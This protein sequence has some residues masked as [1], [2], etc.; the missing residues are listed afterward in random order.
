MIGGLRLVMRPP[1]DP[2][3]TFRTMGQAGG[4]SDKREAPLSRLW[5]RAKAGAPR[6][7]AI[8]STV[9]TVRRS[10]PV[11]TAQARAALIAEAARQGVDDLSDK[12]LSTMTDAV[13][14]SA[15]EGASQA[16][17]K[18]T[19]GVKSLWASLQTSRPEWIE[20]PDDVAA[21]NLRSDQTAVA[22]PVEIEAPALVQR[23]IEDVPAEGDGTRTFEAWLALD[24][25]GVAAVHVGRERLGRVP[26]AHGA[27]VHDE[28]TRRRFWVPGTVRGGVV[29]VGLPD[30]A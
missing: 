12:E 8:A 13:T 1:A 14:T 21:L 5:K 3:T 29:T 22:V 27:A 4:M 16:I 26:A 30:H 24:T 15:K 7:K 11:D 25:A 19:A 17:G 2:R 20:L 9:Y 18:T 23:L 10:K 28:L 6:Q